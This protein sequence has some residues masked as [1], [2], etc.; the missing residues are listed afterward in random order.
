MFLN[1]AVMV[2][3]PRTCPVS[4]C[5]RCHLVKKLTF[6]NKASVGSQKEKKRR[7]SNKNKQEKGTVSEKKENKDL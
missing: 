2:A 6:P 7:N 5:R 3:S 4:E 1:L